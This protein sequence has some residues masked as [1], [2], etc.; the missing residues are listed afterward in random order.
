MRVRSRR[1]VIVVIAFVAAAAAALVLLTDPTLREQA[2]HV[3]RGPEA[4]VRPPHGAFVP[5]GPAG[6]ADV[7]VVGDADGTEARRLA[8]T[9]EAAGADRL[10]YLG[11]VYDVGTSASFDQWS[12]VWGAFAERTAPT[13]GNH[14]WVEAREGYD[15]YWRSVFGQDPPSMYRFSVGGWEI[16]S[17]NSEGAHEAGSLQ[18]RWL[19]RELAAPAGD[20]RLVF[21][22]RPRFSAGP[23]GDEPSLDSFWREL[24]GRA[25]IVLSG[26]EHNLQRLEPQSGV[27]Q[28]VVGA[29]GRGHH[30]LDDADP[31][32]AFADA[33][34]TGGLRLTLT[35]GRALWRFVA[36]GGRVLDAGS[37]RCHTPAD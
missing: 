31:R 30:A 8:A 36:A 12:R 32:L 26:H 7:W 5:D 4:A 29:G 20:C 33:R 14:D 25:Q 17:L 23:R 6:R 10:I 15:P 27:R 9:V 3:V 35:P 18:H 2:E 22:H 16:L 24:G 1:R 28:F 34:H 11:D 13:P 19:R 21:W 37:A